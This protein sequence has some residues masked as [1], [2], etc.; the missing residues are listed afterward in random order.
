MWTLWDI[1]LNCGQSAA[2]GILGVVL[3][4]GPAIKGLLRPGT[5]IKNLLRFCEETSFHG[6]FHQPVPAGQAIYTLSVSR[7]PLLKSQALRTR[8]LDPCVGM[9]FGVSSVA[10]VQP[11]Q[12][13][14]LVC[15]WRHF[16]GALLTCS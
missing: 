11:A 6:S 13:L 12:M 7:N 9:V 2:P 14:L 1:P 4:C 3:T 16:S 10:S 15:A 8:M 5:L